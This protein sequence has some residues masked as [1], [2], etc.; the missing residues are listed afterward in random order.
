MHFLFVYTILVKA[1]FSI[2]FKEFKIRLLKDANG[3]IE[4]RIVR[5]LSSGEI[6]SRETDASVRDRFNFEYAL[7]F[8]QCIDN[9]MCPDNLIFKLIPIGSDFKLNKN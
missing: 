2:N 8:W 1:A 3:K 9:Y 6:L 4:K 5:N 7:S